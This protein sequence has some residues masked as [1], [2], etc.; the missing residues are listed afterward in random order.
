M[1]LHRPRRISLM[2]VLLAALQTGGCS[3]SEA[4]R[5]EA[6]EGGARYDRGDYDAALPLLEKAAAQGL[7]DGEV[8]YQL[9]FIYDLKG[10]AEKAREFRE[11]AGPL[12]EK[13]IASSN[14]PLESYYYLTAL[15]FNLQK[16]EEMKAAA[17]HGIAKFGGA[18]DLSGSDLFRLGRLYQFQGRGDLSAASY[19]RAVERFE[20]EPE[21]NS[22]LYSLAL[23]ADGRTDFQSHRFADARRKLDLSSQLNPKAPDSSFRRGLARLGAGDLD[24]AAALFAQVRDEE[25]LTEAQYALDLV[26]HLKLL[27]GPT[28]VDAAKK[29]LMEMDD[30]FLEQAI[31]SAADAVRKSRAEASTGPESSKAIQESERIFFS[32]TWEWMIRGKPIRETALSSGYADLIRR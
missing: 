29:P 10:Q 31:R 32:L 7:E 18:Q 6:A 24:G 15:Y 20:K 13:R 22:I 1:S 21:P 8:Y 23:D 3:A 14:A 2:L 28:T 12:L 17:E 9:A 27:G 25:H 5:R 30:A 19:H 11:K 4:G 26:R 16:G